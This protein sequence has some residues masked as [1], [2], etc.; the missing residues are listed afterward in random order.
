MTRVCFVKS[1]T[2]HHHKILTRWLH[3]GVSC[4]PLDFI[5]VGAQLNMLNLQPIPRVG[6]GGRTNYRTHL[7]QNGPTG[8]SPY[9][10]PL[11]MSLPHECDFDTRLKQARQFSVGRVVAEAKS[12]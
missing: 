10:T 7:S 2:A 3:V 12:T 5:A 4:Y 9:H 11:L 8:G 6:Q 1:P